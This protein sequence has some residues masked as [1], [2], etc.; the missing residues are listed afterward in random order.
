MG[1]DLFSARVVL[2]EVNLLVVSTKQTSLF[3]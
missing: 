1:D 3:Y 2:L